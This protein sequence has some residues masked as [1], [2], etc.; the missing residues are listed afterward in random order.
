M[1]HLYS[2]YTEPGSLKD[3]QLHCDVPKVLLLDRGR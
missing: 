1:H 2:P 3:M